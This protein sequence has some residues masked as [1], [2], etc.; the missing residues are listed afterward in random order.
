MKGGAKSDQVILNLGASSSKNKFTPEEIASKFLR[1]YTFLTIISFTC[2]LFIISPIFIPFVAAAIWMFRKNKIDE[3]YNNFPKIDQNISSLDTSSLDAFLQGAKSAKS[4]VAQLNSNLP[5]TPA[6]KKYK[7]YYA[8][9][10][11]RKDNNDALI[12]AV[13]TSRFHLD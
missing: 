9:M 2:I 11:A 5:C 8:G 13:E 7:C 10:K 6:F 4:I 1:G 12:A 3:Y